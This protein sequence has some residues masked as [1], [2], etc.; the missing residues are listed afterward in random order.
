[1][2]HYPPPPSNDMAEDNFFGDFYDDNSIANRSPFATQLSQ[3][4]YSSTPFEF[5]LPLQRPLVAVPG[6]TFKLEDLRDALD[7]ILDTFG[8]FVTQRK[9]KREAGIA[10]NRKFP[11]ATTPTAQGTFQA[12]IK[13]NIGEVRKENPN[14]S[15]QDHMRAVGKMWTDAKKTRFYHEAV[16]IT[17]QKR[18]VEDM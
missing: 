5:P 15:H 4:D 6:K 7:G 11:S 2:E 12:F 10:W 3:N 14:A 16:N 1:M 18:T 13:D 17:G 8:T 9:F